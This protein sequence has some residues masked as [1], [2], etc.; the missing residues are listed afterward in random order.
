MRGIYCCCFFFVV[1]V[2]FNF[3]VIIIVGVVVFVDAIAKWT[4]FVMLCMCVFCEYKYVMLSMVMSAIL[5]KINHKSRVHWMAPEYNCLC[6][7]NG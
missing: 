1:V 2:V 3:I 7:A 5:L 6:Y 4:M